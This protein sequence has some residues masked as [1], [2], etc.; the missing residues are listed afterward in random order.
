M[1]ENE[2]EVVPVKLAEVAEIFKSVSGE[3]YA[4]HVVMNEPPPITLEY[5][6]HV[7]GLWLAASAVWAF[8][9]GFAGGVIA[10][11]IAILREAFK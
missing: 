6:F 10:L 9:V 5:C 11:V 1:S 2:Q 4:V 3:K 7:M 8:I